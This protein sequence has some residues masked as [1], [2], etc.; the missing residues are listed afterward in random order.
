ML[1]YTGTKL[2]DRTPSPSRF[3]SKLG[4]R[5]ATAKASATDEFPK[6]RDVKVSRH[7]PDSLLAA[8]PNATSKTADARLGSPLG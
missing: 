2:A 1:L 8:I 6:M 5:I 4:M 7:S 3:C